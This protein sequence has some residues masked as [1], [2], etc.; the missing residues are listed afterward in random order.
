[1]INIKQEAQLVIHTVCASV[2]F[3]WGTIMKIK[4][5]IYCDGQQ[6]HQIQQSKQPPVI[7][8]QNKDHKIW[9]LKSRAWLGTGK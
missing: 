4:E 6:C 8:E 9:H 7:I 5:K 1:M 3:F 2:Y